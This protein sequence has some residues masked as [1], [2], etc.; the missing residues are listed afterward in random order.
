[1]KK[2][3]LALDQGTTGSQAILIDADTFSFVDSAKEEYPQ[4]YPKPSWVEHNLHD[5][6]GSIKHTIA[7]LL[8]KHNIG[9]N[10]IVAIGITNQ[11]ET[12]CAFNKQGEPLCN[13][14]VWQDRRTSKW[15][16][17]HKADEKM[18]KEKTGLPLDPYFSGTKMNWMLENNSTVKDA[19]QDQSLC[20]GTIDTFLLYKLTSGKVHATEAS[21]ASRTL[22]MNLKTGDWDPELLSYFNIPRNA[23]PQIKDSFGHF[24]ETKGLDFL[25]D[26]IP[27]TCLLGDQQ[28]ALFGQGVTSTGGMKCTYGTGAFLLLNIGDEV[29][30]SSNGLLTT[31]AYKYKGKMVYAFEGSSYICGAAVQWLRDNLKLFNTSS[32]VEDLA[33]KIEDLAQVEHIL[34]Y[35]YFSGIGSPYWKPEAKAAIIG[36]TRDTKEEHLSYACLEGIAFSIYE[37]IAA[38][39]KDSGKKITHLRV[40]GGACKNNLLME[41]QATILQTTVERP[42]VVE[43]TGYGAALG[44]A[45]GLGTFDLERVKEKV[46]IEKSFTALRQNISFYE[47]KTKSWQKNF[48]N[49]YL[50]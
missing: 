3:I 42:Q 43:T 2:F 17:D 20:F 24:G 15:C 12:T 5:I 36:M 23:L 13:A 50:S 35:P 16:E 32:A 47:K 19:A 21:N 7:K 10:D 28:A 8:K 49:L 27:V 14:I 31:V 41:M 46:R 33:N 6:W 44:A 29:K 26:G 40:D 38:F 39:E 48:K 18:I 22:L 25:P 37:L 34:F 45:V 30:Y 4:I 9:K 11:R 1:M